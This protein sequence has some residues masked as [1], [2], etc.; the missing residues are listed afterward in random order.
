MQLKFLTLEKWQPL[1]LYLKVSDIFENTIQNT[2]VLFKYSKLQ[3]SNYAKGSHK[4]IIEFCSQ[5]FFCFQQYL[6]NLTI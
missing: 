3:N 6:W 5:I 4:N 2:E 1:E